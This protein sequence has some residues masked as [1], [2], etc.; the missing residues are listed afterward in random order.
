[1]ARALISVTDKT[2]L[3]EFAE[4][5]VQLGIELVST[6]GTARVLKEHHIP[7]VELQ[8]FTEWPEMLDGRVK[9][10]HP[11]VH[12][13]ILARRSLDTHAAQMQTHGL[14]YI[15]LVVVNLYDFHG[16][17]SKPGV[18]ES[19]V[20]E[21]IDIGGP[22]LLRAAAKN[23]EDV[24]VVV[25]PSNYQR[26]LTAL[27]EEKVTKELRRELAALVFQHTARYD[28]AV[29]SFFANSRADGPDGVPAVEVRSIDKVMDLRYGENSHQSAAFFRHSGT[30]QGLARA[31]VIQ[32][33]A[34]SYNNYLDLDAALAISID[35]S[36]YR[37]EPNAVFI[38]HNNPSGVAILS[39]VTEAIRTARSCDALS[40]FGAVVAVS[41][42]LDKAAAEALAE[43]FIEAVIAPGYAPAAL[44]VLAKKKNL[45]VLSL[46]EAWVPAP[47][48]F[49][50]REVRGGVLRQSLDS[51]PDP[52][53][54]T[55]NAKVVT[56]RHPS[57]EEI[58]ALGFA[59]TVAKH[60]KS[61]AIVFAHEDRILAVGAGQMSRVDSVRICEMKAGD[62]LQGSVVASDA[63][64]PFRDG[65]DVLAKAGARAIIQPGG[66][67]RD[68]EVIEAANEH[69]I[70]MLFTGIRH[71]RH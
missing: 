46:D 57:E 61:N 28:S 58:R 48:Q 40:A 56:H 33:K 71:F 31:N 51:C 42:S 65:V 66:S 9:T 34:L 16:T 59:W 69:G 5:L 7:H 45:R 32:G 10:L 63:F 4:G 12:A 20:I 62:E 17:V 43:S 11:R 18:G 50:W 27:R 55:A 70:S 52:G 6:G 35:I 67:I 44:E 68:E 64:F 53:V 49:V 38:K 36:A 3:P 41:R 39:D 30:M 60:V 15:D 13:G 1:M 8:Q 14:D 25:H 21:A 23:Y 47:A 37:D 26:L 24:L 29:A 22:S 54:E 19:E 2:G